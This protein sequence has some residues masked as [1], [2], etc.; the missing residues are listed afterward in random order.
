LAPRSE[1]HSRDC[2][3]LGATAS[4]TLGVHRTAG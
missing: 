2:L 1:Y 3:D 4:N